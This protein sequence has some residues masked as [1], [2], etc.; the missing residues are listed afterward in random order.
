VASP[1]ISLQLAGEVRGD[2]SVAAMYVPLYVRAYM[3]SSSTH[4]SFYDIAILL[5][6]LFS[7]FSLCIR[8]YERDYVK[9][10]G[11]DSRWLLLLLLLSR[12]SITNL[13]AHIHTHICTHIHTHTHTH[14]NICTCTSSNRRIE[15]CYETW[16]LINQ[17]LIVCVYA[18]CVCNVC[19]CNA[20]SVMCV[21]AMYV[22][23]CAMSRYVCMGVCVKV[24]IWVIMAPLTGRWVVTWRRQV[25]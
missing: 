22:C 23:M 11:N 3:R 6:G 19:V 18:V 10:C 4:S 17:A 14:T 20:V 8:M 12:M 15:L 5:A 13:C 24:R 9:A 25:T 1:I 2:W 21:Y 16:C 7:S